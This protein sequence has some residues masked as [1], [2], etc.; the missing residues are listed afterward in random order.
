[1]AVAAFFA[2]AFFAADFEATFFV[3]ALAGATLPVEADFFSAVWE[4]VAFLGF[5]EPNAFSQPE[6]YWEL[7]P[8]RVI[9]M[10]FPFEYRSKKLAAEIL[11]CS[12]A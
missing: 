9:V 8:T 6:A 11:F 1:M 4:P 5:E 12:A 10:S 3:A 7:E 2:G